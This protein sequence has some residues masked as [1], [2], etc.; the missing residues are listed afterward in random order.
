MLAPQIASYFHGSAV[1]VWVQTPPAPLC[2]SLPSASPLQ[3][4]PGITLTFCPALCLPTTISFC[5][6]SLNHHEMGAWRQAPPPR[7]LNLENLFFQPMAELFWV[8]ASIH[9]FLS[10]SLLPRQRSV[11]SP[12]R[13]TE[14][15]GG[16]VPSATRQEQ[17]ADGH[18]AKWRC[19]SLFLHQ[20]GC[21]RSRHPS[22]VLLPW[23]QR[24][25]HGAAV[26]A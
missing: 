13:K 17:E 11:R 2:L 23:E 10:V 5:F 22:H 4:L 19:Q 1:G 24:W 14:G 12:S 7:P 26:T 21:K 18:W 15:E 16:E 6:I 8:C 25:W 9:P 3:N 20:E